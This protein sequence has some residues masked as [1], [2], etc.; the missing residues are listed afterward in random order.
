MDI[1]PFIHI[2]KTGVSVYLGHVL[3]L[4]VNMYHG[5][6]TIKNKQN[7]INFLNLP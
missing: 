3:E 7:L 2:P 6:N 5:S 1:K 4:Q